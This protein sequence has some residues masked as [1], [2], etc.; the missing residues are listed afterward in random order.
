VLTGDSERAKSV[1][2]RSSGEVRCG[3]ALRS[4]V[5]EVVLRVDFHHSRKKSLVPRIG[6]RHPRRRR[7][8]AVRDCLGRE[9]H[10]PRRRAIGIEAAERVVLRQCLLELRTIARIAQEFARR[11]G[12]RGTLR[13]RLHGELV[14]RRDL[15]AGVEPVNIGFR[16]ERADLLATV[17]ERDD[18][19]RSIPL[20][21]HA[22]FLDF[23]HE[24][25]SVFVELVRSLKIAI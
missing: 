14:D 2:L 20:H 12:L 24:L 13:H 8:L 15:A 16:S 3:F 1:A 17:L 11:R 10:V 21:H 23:G 5:R 9:F 6:Q 25:R 22:D 19:D 7:K 4:N 18:V